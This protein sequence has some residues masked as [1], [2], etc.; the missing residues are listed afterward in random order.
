MEGWVLEKV[1]PRYRTIR[2]WG[3]GVAGKRT[4][5]ELPQGF[6]DYVRLIEDLLEVKV[7]IISTGVGRRDTVLIEDELH[8]LVD[9]ARLDPEL[10]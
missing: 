2:G 5:G 10:A 4:W 1:E 8:G 3:T 7:A 9:L 6:R